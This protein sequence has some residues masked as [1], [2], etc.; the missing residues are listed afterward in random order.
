MVRSI[1]RVSMTSREID[2]VSDSEKET[3][4][5]TKVISE[6]EV[7]EIGKEIVRK[8]DKIIA[9]VI[10]SVIIPKIVKENANLNFLLK[11]RQ[12]IT[13]IALLKTLKN[14]Q[15][16]RNNEDHKEVREPTTKGTKKLT[17]MIE[18]NEENDMMTETKKIVIETETTEAEDKDTI[19]AADMEAVGMIGMNVIIIQ[20][21]VVH[22]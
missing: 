20:L 17:V 1:D 9:I 12:E 5:V 10:V 8:I 6:R 7:P 3:D 16:T 18:I 22:H 14:N 13:K 15:L 21:R 19:E 11:N 2:N 4:H